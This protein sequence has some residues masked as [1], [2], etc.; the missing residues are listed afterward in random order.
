MS[1]FS[2]KQTCGET[3]TI[4]ARAPKSRGLILHRHDLLVRVSHWLNV[5]ILLGLIL[6]GMSIY[7]ASPIYQHKPDPQT[8]SFDRLADLGIWICAHLP[9]LHQY[10][11]PPDW[12]YNH[13][14]LGPG[15]LASALRL[16]WLCAYLF[17]LNGLVYVTGLVIGGGWRALLPR[18][19]DL[20][21]ALRMMRY[22][23]GV[24]F[25]FVL[26]RTWVYPQFM[27]K[28]N[29]LQRLAYFSVPVAG[30]LSVFTGWAIH[31]PMQLHWLAAIFGG[32][33]KARIWH[34]WL[35]WLFILFVV[36]HV[37]LVLADGWDTLRSMIV[38]WSTRA[39]ETGGD[40]RTFDNEP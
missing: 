20:R 17:M 7:W 6:S 28:Y 21:D 15:M 31:K 4:G 38:G 11:S 24:P 34:F 16:H 10:S 35:M 36:P 32:Y 39:A 30:L 14:S 22:Y 23:I 9:G 12:V 13:I 29:A 1:V 27:T 3:M 26:R 19:T 2:G 18:S 25:A 40:R 37:I 8:G 5:P 33:D